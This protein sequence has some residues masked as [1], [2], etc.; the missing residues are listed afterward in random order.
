MI[1]SLTNNF[2]KPSYSGIRPIMDNKNKSMRDFIIQMEKDHSI[3]NLINLYGIE[4]PGLT[5]ALA[6]GKYIKNF[7]I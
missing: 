1:I 5:S 3:P 4:S 7:L 6:I 2:L